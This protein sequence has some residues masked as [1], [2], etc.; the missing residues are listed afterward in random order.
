MATEGIVQ[1]LS[2]P[3]TAASEQK[4]P[5]VAS[6]ANRSGLAILV[7]PLATGLLLWLCYYPLDWGWLGWVALVPFLT[8]VRVQA[9]EWRVGL[10]A[11]LG[12]V[13]FFLPSLQWMRVADYRMYATWVALA[14]Y[15]ALYFPLA[16]YF[17]RRLNRGTRLPLVLSAPVVWTALEFLRTYLLTGFPWYYLGHSQHHFLPFIQIADI[18]GAYLISFLVAMVN[19]LIFEWLVWR[20]R[21]GAGFLNGRPEKTL[22]LKALAAYTGLVLVLLA[23][24]LAYGGW[25]LGESEFGKGPRVALIQGNLDQHIRNDA[26]ESELNEAFRTVVKHFRDL[27]DQAVHQPDL[28]DLIVWPETSY[29]KEWVEVAADLPA[30]R[31]PEIWKEGLADS[32]DLMEKAAKRWRT[33]LLLGVSCEF[34]NKQGEPERYNSA[35]YL[36][37]D[38]TLG[39]RYDKIHRVP[40][41]EYVP[42]R[43]ELPFMNAFAP[44]D[45]DYSI[46]PGRQMTRFRL[47]GFHFGVLICYEDT[48]P[49]LARKYLQV[50]PEQP[51]ADFLINISNDGW[52]NG[53][54]EHEEHLSICRFRAV[55]CRRAVAR[56]VNMG[57][58]AVIDGNGRIVALP[59]ASWAKSKKIPAV[60]TA[61]IPID[62]RSSLYVRFGDWL[63]WL[64]WCV[65]LG[66]LVWGLLVNRNLSGAAGRDPASPALQICPR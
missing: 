12:G 52:F 59:A 29:P 55:E 48:D 40:F 43:A 20:A 56:A 6:V 66:G 64:C 37:P 15:C 47:H 25:R 46:K 28:P 2:S 7:A 14:L 60:V 35:I 4:L 54:S 22:S 23:L 61:E 57:I 16:I 41:G 13:A 27:S 58:S 63:V 44:Y 31:I 45:F 53:T 18:G 11:W 49:D 39:G 32:R 8:L 36:R 10:A 62:T 24:A 38:R 33:N 34:L 30:D 19:G 3:F 21:F 26:S 5:R 51:V 17:L 50:S 1:R 42:L 9:G 65:L